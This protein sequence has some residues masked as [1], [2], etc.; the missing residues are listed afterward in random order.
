MGCITC[1][2]CMGLDGNL[3]PSNCMTLRRKSLRVAAVEKGFSLAR[4][5]EK[6]AENT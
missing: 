1:V 5:K 3:Q 4:K 2:A 6:P